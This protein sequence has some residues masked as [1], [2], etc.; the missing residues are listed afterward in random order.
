M[1]ITMLGISHHTA[2]L[3][4]REKLALT[5]EQMQD[6][7]AIWREQYPLAQLVL[8]STCNRSEWYIA[9][10]NQQPPDEQQLQ[11][12]ITELTGMDQQ[13]ISSVS[14]HRENQEAVEH[15]LGVASGLDSMVLGEP[16]ILGQIKTAYER[17]VSFKCVDTALHT[18]FQEALAVGKQ[19]RTTTGIDAGRMS[20]G[21][22]AIDFA[23]QIFERFDDKTAVAIGAG[24]IA[25]LTLRHLQNLSPKQLWLVNR[26]IDR[27]HR[28]ADKLDVAQVRPFDELDDLLVEVDMVI[29][30]TG[31]PKPIITVE[32]FRPLHKKRRSRP[33]F[34]I[35]LAVPRDV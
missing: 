19:V 17:A 10:P 22:V 1:I 29:T 5:P 8:L 32:R 20:V 2:P 13:T 7:M 30:S 21:S 25:K 15:L 34:I 24:D 9:R 12:F 3:E 6:A 18:L 14:I 35:D 11:S 23:S 31:A 26:S 4:V 28:L 16:Q 27:A 33:L